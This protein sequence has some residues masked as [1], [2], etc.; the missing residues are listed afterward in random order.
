MCPPSEAVLWRGSHKQV[1]D[2]PG[3]PVSPCTL[4]DGLTKRLLG[5][6]YDMILPILVGN[7]CWQDS[8]DL[9]VFSTNNGCDVC[10]TVVCDPFCR[11]FQTEEAKTARHPSSP[12]KGHQGISKRLKRFQVSHH[13][14]PCLLQEMS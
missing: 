11:I 10:L 3:K 1:K 14:A 5:L 8:G 9:P 13:W 12:F 2:T 7:I 4:R 6:R